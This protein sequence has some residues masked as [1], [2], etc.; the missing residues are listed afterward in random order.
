VEDNAVRRAAPTGG[1]ISV[2]AG[3]DRRFR[4]RLRDADSTV[5]NTILAV[6]A[7]FTIVGLV[8]LALL[9]YPLR[10]GNVAWEFGTLNTTFDEL[11]MTA[12]GVALVTLGLIAHPRLGG[13]WVRAAA[14]F[15]VVATVLL[16]ALAVLYGLSA[17]E[18]MGRAPEESMGL[19]R[20]AVLK[21]AAE[22][23]AY[24]AASGL[25]AV[26]CWRGVERER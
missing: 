11:P 21:N 17:I 20:R 9:W 7:A 3:R 12:L 18:V 16:V 13:M 26:I 5:A 24:V 2:D 15:Y 14:V 1:I 6:G 10:F 22:I 19:L 25:V 8:D 4:F 23:A